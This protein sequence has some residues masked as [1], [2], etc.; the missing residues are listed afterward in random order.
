MFYRFSKKIGLSVGRIGLLLGPVFSLIS[1]LFFPENLQH[2]NAHIM[3]AVVTLM[4]VWWLTEA[5]PLGATALLPLLLF[6]LTGLMK[7]GDIASFYMN[8]TI[9][10][11]IGGFI[12]ALAMEQWKLHLRIAVWIIGFFGSDPKYTLLGMMAA[13]AGLSMWISNTAAA[14]LMLPIAIAFVEELR[15]RE[16]NVVNFEKALLIGVAYACSIG[17]IATLVGTPPNLIFIR[18]FMQ[19]FPNLP[20][21][22]FGEWLLFTLPMSLLLLIIFWLALSKILFPFKKDILE[23]R[24]EKT[25]SLPNPGPLRYEEAVILVVFFLT[26]ALW[27]FRTDIQI[28]SV[29]IPGWSRLFASGGMIDDGTIAV[30]ASLLLFVIPAKNRGA[31]MCQVPAGI[32]DI[33]VFKKIPWS[34]VLLFGGGFALA[35]GFSQSGLASILAVKFEILK[36]VP[37]P[38][39]VFLI[40]ISV[41]F[42]TELTSNTAVAQLVLPI[43]AGLSRTLQVNPLLLMIPA[44]LSAS[45][46]FMMPIATP[47]NAIVFGTER[48]KVS[49]MAFGGFFL[50]ILCAVMIT[51]FAYFFVEMSNEA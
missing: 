8:S 48:L 14:L 47:P 20:V 23:S 10:L 3:A 42:A 51:L 16:M 5:I 7:G 11:F 15:N 35:A 21:P 18:I 24:N 31:G 25:A 17:G 33:S 43:L 26:A 37:L 29:T 44:T 38:V 34:I 40:A 27:I 13:A 45:M 6:P 19:E 30:M 36:N 4:A 39:T 2:P 50:N 12:L 9:F 28:A 1:L 41:S 49:D 22:S 32:V 46:A